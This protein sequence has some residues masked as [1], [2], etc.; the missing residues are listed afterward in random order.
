MVKILVSLCILYSNCISL[1]M[2]RTKMLYVEVRRIKFTSGTL[3]G[4]GGWIMEPKKTRQKQLIWYFKVSEEKA[5]REWMTE[6]DWEWI[7]VQC[8]L[9][10]ERREW[11]A[12]VLPPTRTD[13]CSCSPVNSWP[14]RWGEVRGGGGSTP[15]R[16]VSSTFY[17]L[18]TR[19]A[20]FREKTALFLDIRALKL[21]K[22]SS[23]YNKDKYCF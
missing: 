17:T 19:N 22:L 18:D 2:C 10:W 3:G 11:K 8:V 6:C 14:G 13:R 9:R 16:A 5:H 21:H 15:V 20:G 23:L 7:K 1:K 4:G 12:C